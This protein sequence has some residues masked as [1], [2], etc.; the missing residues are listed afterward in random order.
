M[1]EEFNIQ[2]VASFQV[3][4]RD[5]KPKMNAYYPFLSQE[6]IM[7][8]LRQRWKQLD[9]SKRQPY[10]KLVLS[11]KKVKTV[12]VKV[13]KITRRRIPKDKQI[14]TSKNVNFARNDDSFGFNFS[15][16]SYINSNYELD[17][18]SEHAPFMGKKLAIASLNSGLCPATNKPTGN[19]K[20]GGVRKTDESGAVGLQS[21]V[22]RVRN[23]SVDNSKTG[24]LQ[25]PR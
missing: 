18:V 22:P 23:E 2:Q 25:T 13:V 6:Q 10:C 1:V 9:E 15:G 19:V 8:K 17:S 11:R 3:F 12:K 7:L 16:D 4:V 5:N 21:D 14:G 20:K 24:I